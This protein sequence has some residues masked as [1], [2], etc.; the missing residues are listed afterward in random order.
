MR[1]QID[2]ENRNGKRIFP[3]TKQSVTSTKTPTVNDIKA[4]K[5]HIIS[6]DWT[7]NRP[8]FQYAPTFFP[9]SQIDNDQY[10]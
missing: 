9:D 5:P 8:N 4:Q 1:Q 10:L 3:A 2:L 6:I 7:T